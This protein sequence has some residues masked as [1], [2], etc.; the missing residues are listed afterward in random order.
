[1]IIPSSPVNIYLKVWTIFFWFSVV[2]VVEFGCQFSL[3]SQLCPTL[4]DP[5]DGSTPGFLVHH[6]LP[7]LSQTHVPQVWWCHPTISFLISFSSCLLSFSASGAFSMSQFFAPG[8]QS[9]GISA[10]VLSMNN[11]DW[12][13][14]GLT[15]WISLLSKGPSRVFF[16][17]TLP[18]HQFSHSQ[19]SL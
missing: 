13:P 9:I 19:L 17:F 8:D 2:M 15:G 12:F 18:K 10:S 14:L 11:W 3:V 5:M 16:N 4:C 1:M 6:Q 7:E